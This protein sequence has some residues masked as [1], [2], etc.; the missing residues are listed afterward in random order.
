MSEKCFCHLNGYEVKDAKA[1][2]RLDSLSTEMSD[3]KS[4]LNNLFVDG[5]P[6]EGNME[7]I[8]IRHGNNGRD[9][10]TAGD[11]V[12]YQTERTE[13]CFKY[14]NLFYPGT[15]HKHFRLN[16]NEGI[17]EGE[18][19]K[20]FDETNGTRKSF[21]LA[22]NYTVK[23]ETYYITN[24]STV[25]FATADEKYISH[26]SFVTGNN[27][28]L[29]PANCVKLWFD[30]D[31]TIVPTDTVFIYEGTNIPEYTSQ[32]SDSVD[33]SE[34]QKNS[35]SVDLINTVTV[36]GSG[37]ISV[38]D[39]SPE[40][41]KMEILTNPATVLYSDYSLS[42][43]DSCEFDGVSH[44]SI[45]AEAYSSILLRPIINGSV[46]T[47]ADIN[48]DID[49]ELYGSANLLYSYSIT[50]T[51][52]TV[53]VSGAISEWDAGDVSM[54]SYPY[55]RTITATVE[56]GARITGIVWPNIQSDSNVR[57]KAVTTTPSVTMSSVKNLL[58][59]TQD[60][61]NFDGFIYSGL[62]CELLNTNEIRWHGEMSGYPSSSFHKFTLPAGT[63]TFS[64][65]ANPS[66]PYNCFFYV[67]N[68][69]WEIFVNPGETF[70]LNEKTSLNLWFNCE[71]SEFFDFITSF[72]IEQGT[73]ASPIYPYIEPVTYFTN[74]IGYLKIDSVYPGFT[75][76]TDSPEISLK[77][78]RDITKVFGSYTLPVATGTTLGGVRIGSGIQ[79][80]RNGTI[81]VPKSE[82]YTLPVATGTTLGGVKIGS[83]LN[84]SNDGTI[85]VAGG[86]GGSV[87]YKEVAVDEQYS[88]LTIN[89]ESDKTLYIWPYNAST[90]GDDSRSLDWN[91]LPN[92]IPNGFSF[93]ICIP[94]NTSGTTLTSGTILLDLSQF[95]NSNS[96]GV[97]LDYNMMMTDP[98][99]V[100]SVNGS[101]ITDLKIY[102][103]DFLSSTEESQNQINVIFKYE[104]ISNNRIMVTPSYT[105]GATS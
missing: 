10:A 20:L 79:V 11:S 36:S 50:G 21:S 17:T 23:P 57:F 41:H 85:S 28:F 65:N 81:S 46:F 91:L 47:G 34:K 7:L 52:L 63:Y 12:R 35:L 104:K 26:V 59:V 70:T 24:A 94:I 39:V 83:G 38:D 53:N 32:L 60:N 87:E 3:T 80:D 49:P 48:I 43:G 27:A 8:D 45:T 78:K 75:I 68:D 93:A 82:K 89:N 51:V 86:V 96:N 15:E 62:T 16:V 76:E 13:N 5:T 105:R 99:N 92:E 101:E 9:Y 73:T 25:V 97:Y 72:Q 58:N 90:T 95:G 103:N 69:S 1:R 6:T 42:P 71:E 61:C 22:E 88:I 29:T 98:K 18:D 54:V 37:Y 33:L 44:V 2:K 4:R 64:M 67:V 55:E 74:E 84:V 102:N 56:A 66:R 14:Y 40:P 19:I 100:F 77:Y 31:T 30:W